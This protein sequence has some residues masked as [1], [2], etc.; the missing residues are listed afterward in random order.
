MRLNIYSLILI[1]ALGTA[2]KSGLQGEV[3]MHVYHTRSDYGK[4]KLQID[5]QQKGNIPKADQKLSCG[6][7]D[8][9][10]TLIFRLKHG[11][12]KVK[13]MDEGGQIL[14]EGELEV[15]DDNLELKGIRGG[16]DARQNRDC[17]SL[18]IL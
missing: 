14:A 3:E 4:L 10:S 1:A 18:E 8:L 5:D 6:D 7:E 17:V 16:M 15:S 12:Y 2:C 9:D 13:A 11:K